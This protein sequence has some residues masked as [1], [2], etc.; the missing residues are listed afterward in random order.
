MKVS[1]MRLGDVAML[2]PPLPRR[3]VVPNELVA[4]APMAAVSAHTSQEFISETRLFSSVQNGFSYFRDGDV[5]VA[6]ITPCFENGKITQVRIQERHGFGST[7][8]HVVRAN[9]GKVDPRYL[10]HFLRQ[11]WVRLKGQRRMTGSAGQRRV[12]KDFLAGL[13]I[14]T[15]PLSEQSRIGAILDKADAL[16]VKRRRGIATLDALTQSLFLDL[17]GDVQENTKRWPVCTVADYV[18]EFQGG[19]SIECGSG[20]DILTRYRVLKVSA[21]TGMRFLAGESKPV[22]VN[23]EPPREHFVRPGDLLFSRANTTE[24]V[25]AVAYVK[26]TPPNILLPDKLW[27]FVWRDPTAIEPLFIWALFQTGALRR[28]IGRRATG[29]S[30]SM[31]NISQEKLFGIRTIFPPIELQREFVHRISV[32]ETLK[33]MQGRSLA[34]LDALFVTLQ[35][36]AFRG[37]L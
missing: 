15:P 35:Y 31:K 21:V 29:T 17:F 10:I 26:S 1:K 32:V 12:P 14:P 23:Y 33:T 11:D 13:E 7:E 30:G 19:K 34:K 5:L 27:R 6:K 37:E 8:F 24:L 3:S 2:N 20:E 36:R 25:G 18:R 16:R 22:P 28:E 4:F 9:E